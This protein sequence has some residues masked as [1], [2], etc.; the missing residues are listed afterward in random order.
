MGIERLSLVVIVAESHRF[1][2]G[3]TNVEKAICHRH[4]AGR[5]NSLAAHR[6]YEKSEPHRP[7]ISVRTV[8]R[9]LR[10]KLARKDS[11]VSGNV[12]IKKSARAEIVNIGALV[13]DCN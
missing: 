9:A 2:V 10:M 11:L 5:Q 4:G 12:L 1:S 8:A 6:I 7:G 13:K 3:A